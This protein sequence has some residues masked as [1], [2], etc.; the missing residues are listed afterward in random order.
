MHTQNLSRKNIKSN[1]TFK[2]I[3]IVSGF[4]IS[5]SFIF[6]TISGLPAR[7]NLLNFA[8]S[9]MVSGFQSA[10]ENFGKK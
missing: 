8:T 2:K 4:G 3:I 1:K 7:L 9:S 10:S 5:L 6:R